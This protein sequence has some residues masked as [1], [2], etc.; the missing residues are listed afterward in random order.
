MARHLANIAKF[1]D[2]AGLHL[3]PRFI[4]KAEELGEG[5]SNL[6][7]MSAVGLRPDVRAKNHERRLWV[8]FV[9]KLAELLRLGLI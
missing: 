7:R 2:M 1:G 8:Y 6:R 4:E 3:S 9:E 5:I